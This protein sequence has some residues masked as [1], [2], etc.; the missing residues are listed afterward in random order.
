MKKKHTILTIQFISLIINLLFASVS[1]ATKSNQIDDAV[2]YNKNSMSESDISNFIAN[3]PN[4]CLLPKNYPTNLSSITFQ[5]PLSYFN[6]G[7]DASPARIIWIASQLYNLNP[8][9][10]LTTLEKEQN[11]V[12][13]SQGCSFK[14]YNSAMGYNCPEKYDNNGN[15]II[16]N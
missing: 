15:V 2:F 16:Y 8:Q 13:G 5:E 7:S 9:V 1:H 3:K 10:I 14:R 6:Y 4:S 12:S 11:L